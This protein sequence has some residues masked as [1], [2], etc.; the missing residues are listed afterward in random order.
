MSFRPHHVGDLTQTELHQ[1]TNE[2]TALDLDS[3]V[4]TYEATANPSQRAPIT[5][6]TGPSGGT[7]EY[8][9]MPQLY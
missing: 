8:M 7:Y 2:N 9:L 5:H 6:E 3:V 1:Q 4:Q